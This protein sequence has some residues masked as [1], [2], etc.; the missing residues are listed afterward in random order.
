MCH[1]ELCPCDIY[2]AS[3]HLQ[4][5]SPEVELQSQR[6]HRTWFSY[7]ISTSNDLSGELYEVI[8]LDISYTKFSSSDL[9]GE[10]HV[11][12]L[13]HVS[14]SILTSSDLI[15]EWHEVILIDVSYRIAPLWYLSRIPSATIELTGGRISKWPHM[16]QAFWSLQWG[17]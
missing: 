8:L 9:T 3:R 2:H 7:K 6:G 16:E 1:T 17:H 10:W 5:S 15:G 11:V 13:L 14:Y 4:L 12:I